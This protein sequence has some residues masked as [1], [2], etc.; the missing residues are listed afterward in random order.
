MSKKVY[1]TEAAAVRAAKK[2]TGAMYA[3]AFLTYEQANGYGW[4]FMGE[5]I[6]A[7]AEALHGFVLCKKRWSNTPLVKTN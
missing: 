6:P 1:R 7:S 3:R 5:N 4:A 2:S